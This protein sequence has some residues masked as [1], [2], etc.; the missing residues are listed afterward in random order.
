MKLQSQVAKIKHG[1]SK[2][3]RIEFIQPSIVW[4]IWGVAIAT[5]KQGGGPEATAQR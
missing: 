4:N 5:S 3:I 2:I 1:V